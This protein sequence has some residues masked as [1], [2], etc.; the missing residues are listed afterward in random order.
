[1]ERKIINRPRM[2]RIATLLFL[3]P[4]IAE[5]LFG[6]TSVSMLYLLVP[7]VC[8]Y[9]GAALMIHTVARRRGW[10]AV[11]ILGI[12]FAIAEECIILQTSVSPP[13]QHLL[14]G[15]APNPN[16]LGALGINWAY[17]L[18][19][20]GY[21]S[22]WAILLPILLT[23]LIFPGRRAEPWIGRRGLVVSMI[24]FLVPSYGIWYI[25][26]QNG[27]APGLAYEAPLPLVLASL[28]IVVV[29]V[30]FGLV[31]S[32]ADREETKP[33]R[34]VPSPWK[35]GVIAF[36]LSLPWFSLAILP[37]IIPK[38]VSTPLCIMIG[39]IWAVAAFLLIRHW[40]T[41][42]TW[43]ETH[44]LALVFGALLASMLA[45]FII[46]GPTLSSF[47]LAGKIV[48]NIIAILLL[49]YLAHKV[50]QRAASR[51]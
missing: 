34:S 49:A 38:S 32:W 24:V 27:I 29:L 19:A 43:Q 44:Q 13:Y 5:V 10:K 51:S 26:T 40:A 41:S 20:L 18:W 36:L 15:S 17:L 2:A 14:F 45:G 3:S 7:Q 4:V 48:L 16:Y 25:F 21:E 46:T 33:A 35:L 47:D 39:L 31:H 23:E 8:I 50:R 28:G 11:L 6:S 42:S 1:M 12:A 30:F 37:Y 22:V 9:G